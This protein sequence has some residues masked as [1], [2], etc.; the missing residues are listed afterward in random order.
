MNKEKKL[1]MLGLATRARALVSGDE[2]VEKAIKNR[3][4][5]LIICASDASIKTIERYRMISEREN[6]PLNNE[7]TKYELS[8]AIG[9][10]RA[11]LGIDNK[12]MA[13]KFLSYDMESEESYD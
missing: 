13:S 9:K 5:H 11:I 2:I 12:G 3:Q 8:H 1:N 4:V 7:F 6:I 10:S